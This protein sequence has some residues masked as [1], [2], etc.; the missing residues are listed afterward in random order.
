[1]TGAAR[2]G[3]T[4]AKT[5]IATIWNEERMLGVKCCLDFERSGPAVHVERKKQRVIGYTKSQQW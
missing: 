1:M 4:I 2:V 5:P 3:S